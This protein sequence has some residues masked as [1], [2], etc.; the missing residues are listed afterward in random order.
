MSEDVQTPYDPGEQPPGNVFTALALQ[1]QTI[2]LEIAHLR[3]AQLTGNIL[4][5]YIEEWKGTNQFDQRKKKQEQIEGIILAQVTEQATLTM[6]IAE[7]SSEIQSLLTKGSD[8][9]DD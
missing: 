4:N 2:Q 5:W 8:D 9:G 6:R 3:R 1:L 7:T